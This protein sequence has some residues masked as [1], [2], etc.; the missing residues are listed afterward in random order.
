[1]T[2]S[3]G[4][5]Y[6]FEGPDSVGKSTLSRLFADHLGGVGEDCVHLAFPGNEDGTIGSLVYKIHHVPQ[7][8]GIT[9]PSYAALQ[10]LHVAAHIDAIQK[11]I[12]PALSAGKSVVLDRFWW[13][14]LV[15]G[16]VAGL[17]EALL[18]LMISP[19][20]YVWAGNFP[21][22]VFLLERSNPFEFPV[23]EGWLKCA[24]LYSELAVVQESR[25]RVIRISNEGSIDD[26]LKFAVIN[27]AS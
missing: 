23:S 24:S 18:G 20:D 8:L 6:V 27:R 5:L 26:A 22:A 14:T 10:I 21:A 9:E 7:E 11:R 16:R 2:R 19:E 12:I 25:H 3:T 17:D 13:S 1:M 15:Y 4:K